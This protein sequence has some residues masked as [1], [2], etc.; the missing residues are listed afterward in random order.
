M[1]VVIDTSILQ[2]DRGFLQSD[3]LLIKKLAKLDLLKIHIP[4]IVYKE[5]TS[6]NI[7]E[8]DSVLTKSIRE[9]SSLNKKGISEKDYIEIEKIFIDS[10][11]LKTY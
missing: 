4:W 9:I 3:I 2:R 7:K 5:S 1:N 10:I 11:P 8:S 6:Q